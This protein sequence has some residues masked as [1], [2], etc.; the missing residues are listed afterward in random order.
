[1][2]LYRRTV[3]GADLQTCQLLGLPYTPKP[4]TTL[5]EKFGINAAASIGVNEK[6]IMQYVAIGIGGH[7][8]IAGAGGKIK[9][10]P[11]QHSA[12]DAALYEHIPFV[13]RPLDNDLSSTEM[14]RFA[15]RKVLTHAGVDYAAYYLRRIDL[16]GV[17]TKY[18]KKTVLAGVETVT[19]F[20]PDASCLS[21]VAPTTAPGANTTDGTYIYATAQVK[22]AFD[23]FD[24]TEILNATKLLYGQEDYAILSEFGFC[25]GIDRQMQAQGNGGST[26]NMNE[27]VCA[28][29]FC[30]VFGLQPAYMQKGGFEAIYDIG[31][32]EPL[33]VLTGP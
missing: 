11:V 31:I 1:M 8:A 14:A 32:S 24:I 29:V 3:Y 30:H 17:S 28:Q 22:I 19:D 2:E 10:H 13:M 20:V 16:A 21:P 25:T 27:V 23:A 26:F 5:N 15:L 18:K 4:H 7:T 33:M 12:S 9:I 6:P